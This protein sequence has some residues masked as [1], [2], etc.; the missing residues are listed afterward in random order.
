MTVDETTMQDIVTFHGHMCPGLAIGVVAAEIAIEELGVHSQDHELVAVTETDM[1]G[2]D[3]VQFMT[4][5]TFGK[6]NLMYQDWGKTVFTFFRTTDGRAIRIASKPE[7]PEP[8]LEH[9]AL[10]AK[11]RAGSATDVEHARFRELH[12]NR[13]DMVFAMDRN[14]LFTVERF[15]GSPPPNDRGARWVI[16][17]LCGEGVVEAKTQEIDGKVHCRPCAAAAGPPT[18]D[19]VNLLQ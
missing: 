18:S 4:G 11:V 9:E 12:Q 3:A 2:V 19:R 10:F 7:I 14:A 6:G 17:D 8:D 16:C 1:C 5:C 13:S 15:L